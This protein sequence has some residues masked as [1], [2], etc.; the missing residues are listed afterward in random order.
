MLFRRSKHLTTVTVGT[1]IL[2]LNHFFL[3]TY[4]YVSERSAYFSHLKKQ[5]KLIAD[6]GLPVP[7]VYGNVRNYYVFFLHLP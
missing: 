4:F 5:K 2:E 3:I 7:P 6:R 1:L